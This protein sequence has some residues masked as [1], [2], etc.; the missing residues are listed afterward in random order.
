MSVPSASSLDLAQRCQHPWSA[1]PEWPA[2]AFASSASADLGT[3]VHAAI[4]M[5]IAN[6]EVDV[7]AVM[8]AHGLAGGDA[9]TGGAMVREALDFVRPM[10]ERGALLCTE[11]PLALDVRTG[12]ARVLRSRGHRDCAGRREHEIV[13]TVD[14]VVVDHGAVSVHD[15]KTGR[16]AS[17]QRRGLQL[18]FAAV[19][20]AGLLDADAVRGSYVYISEDGAQERGR[21][22]LDALDIYEALAELREVYQ[23]VRRGPSA[24]VPGPHCAEMWCPMLGV[25]SATASALTTVRDSLADVS[26][27]ERAAQVW[28]QI[29]RIEAAIKAAKAELQAMVR[30]RPVRLLNGKRLAL[31]ERSAQ[32]VSTLTPEA[33]AWLHR[34]GL[35]EALDFSTS[36]AA[37]KRAGGAKKAR[38]AMDALGE[39]GCVRPSTYETLS[40]MD[41]EDDDA[42][43]DERS[44]TEE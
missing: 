40:E 42:S 19:A 11:V 44:K 34:E 21:I 23:L 30:R 5:A 14:L 32:R 4:D 35:D 10:V 15:W 33:V 31:V 6:G 29:P 43:D 20:M 2:Q 36:A 22:E 26:T 25:C 38:K 39:M 18:R 9:A 13:G 12:Q 24:P 8:R 37:L 41:A 1:V 16:M 17:S 28:E 27:E 7:P 3:A